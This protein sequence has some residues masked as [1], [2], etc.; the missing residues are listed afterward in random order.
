MDSHVHP[1][2]AHTVLV[3]VLMHLSLN[4]ILIVDAA[5]PIPKTYNA[6][7]PFSMPEGQVAAFPDRSVSIAEY[8]AV[9]DGQMQRS[10]AEAIHGEVYLD[11]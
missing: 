11:E 4:G 8:G 6:A 7:L 10:S 3:L 1:I 9:A 2:Q 5:Q